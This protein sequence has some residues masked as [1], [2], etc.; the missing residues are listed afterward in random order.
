MNQKK[1]VT[2][3]R[4]VQEFPGAV[5]VCDT[6][7]T[8]LEMNE[9]AR[10]SCQKEGGEK[11][12]GTNVLECHPEPARTKLKEILEKQKTNVYTVEKGGLKKLIHQGPW[13]LE[14][15]FA[16]IVELSL[17]IPFEMPNFVREG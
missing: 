3:H 9:K 16:G 10:K 2:R 4:W 11:L 15:K 1:S 13:Y 12:I 5:F 7:G 17:E 14:G 8:I 6:K